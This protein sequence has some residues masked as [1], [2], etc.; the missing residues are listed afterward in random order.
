[1]L[2]PTKLL[3]L[4]GASGN[5]RFWQPV[6]DLLAC[7][8]ER[9]H[10]GWPGF[11]ATPQQPDSV[12]IDDLVARV[13][14]D[15]D[16]PTALIAQS[17]GA[18]IALRAALQKPDLVTHLILS[19]TSGGIDISDL[20]AQDWR[21]DF[22]AANP[23]FPRWFADHDQNLTP[24]QLND[25]RIPVLL[26]WGDADPVSPVAVGQRLA[27]MLPRSALHVISGGNHD[28]GHACA[29]IV[30][31]LIQRFLTGASPKPEH[32]SEPA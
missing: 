13:V 27:S 7:P 28:L 1:M 32:S 6:A 3:F 17:M 21:P 31:P 29:D 12:G 22:H 19:V 25:I 16:R 20:G 9:I 8:G 2:M 15:I 18:V 10:H 14:A 4:P 11:G 23:T 30:A 5:T 26:L 24:L